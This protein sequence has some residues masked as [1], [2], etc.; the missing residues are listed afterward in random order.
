MS[1]CSCRDCRALLSAKVLSVKGHEG[2]DA[3]DAGGDNGDP[4]D[5]QYYSITVVGVIDVFALTALLSFGK[6]AS[7]VVTTTKTR[8]TIDVLTVL[9]YS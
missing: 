4:Y 5:D 9:S 1:L 7:V 2:C 3:D 8:M 6:S